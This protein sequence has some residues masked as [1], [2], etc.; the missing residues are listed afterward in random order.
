MSET[1]AT[2]AKRAYSLI[3]QLIGR[4]SLHSTFWR[5]VLAQAV[6]IGIGAG[7]LRY[8]LKR[9]VD[10][11]DSA[12]AKEA[13]FKLPNIDHTITLPDGRD[14]GYAQYGS[15]D[16]PAILHFHGFPGSRLEGALYHDAALKLGVQVITID[17][18][19]IGL[20]SPHAQRST[21]TCVDDVEQLVERLELKRWAVMGI[22]GGGPY[23]LACAR[24]RPVGLRA[25][26]LVAAMGPYDVDREGMSRGNRSLFYC[27]EHY[28][29]LVRFFGR[30][31]MRQRVFLT[32]N[33]IVEAMPKVQ[34]PWL[35]QSMKPSSKE[36]AVLLDENVMR[37]FWRSS[38]E[39]FKRGFEPFCEEGRILTSDQGF[40]LQDLFDSIPIR[41]WY[42]KEDANVG[43]HMGLRIAEKLGGIATLRMKDE[44]HAGLFVTTAE[45]VLRDLMQYL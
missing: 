13:S 14:L 41:L 33:M 26:A 5:L 16:G 36:M 8:Y 37:T 15:Q 27:F 2:F 3:E 12:K 22:S 25:V 23:A 17:R 21:A 30:L 43:P 35:P 45:D 6:C 20:S 38:C 44:G 42:G 11:T 9:R 28:P 32:E 39:F 10:T 40:K 4:P 7:V 19:G 24:F 34:R 18:P 31:Y 1:L 29:W